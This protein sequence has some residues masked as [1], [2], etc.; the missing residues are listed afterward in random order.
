MAT[1]ETPR[2][3]AEAAY[4]AFTDEVG[5]ADTRSAWDRIPYRSRQC[6]I[7]AA[8]AAR[9]FGMPIPTTEERS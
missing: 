7:K 4:L 1:T 3:A 5:T 9:L 2:S 6:W 8:E